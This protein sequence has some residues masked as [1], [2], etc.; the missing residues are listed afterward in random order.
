MLSRT[1]FSSAFSSKFFMLILMAVSVF[2]C[3][4]STFYF[5]LCEGWTSK[6]H[7]FQTGIVDHLKQKIILSGACKT[8]WATMTLGY[9]NPFMKSPGTSLCCK[10][11]CQRRVEQDGD[12]WWSVAPYHVPFKLLNDGK[13]C[14]Y[15]PL[16]KNYGLKLV[17]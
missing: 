17:T 8:Y 6:M 9:G 5:P 3:S 7:L 15:F 11:S 12:E 2:A 13:V 16:R 1:F 14:Y 10:V 4:S